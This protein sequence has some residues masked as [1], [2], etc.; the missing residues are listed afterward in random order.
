L[1]LLL[2]VCGVAAVGGLLLAIAA[3]VGQAA[4]TAGASQ[5]LHAALADAEARGSVHL[6]TSDV[7]N[8]EE[9]TFADDVAT[10]AG[11]R[12]IAVSDGSRAQIVVTGQ[13]VYISGNRQALAGYFGFSAT[14]AAR[15]G[16][17]WFSTPV[18]KIGP[19]ALATAAVLPSAL[20]EITPAA[21]LTEMTPSTLG[22]EA[23]I[24]IQGS[25]PAALKLPGVETLYVSR[26]PRPLPVFATIVLTNPGNAGETINTT[27]GDWGERVAI[28]TPMHA[29]PLSRL[30]PAK[31]APA[32]PPPTSG[33]TAPKPGG[34]DFEQTIL[35]STFP[36]G[37]WTPL[38]GVSGGAVITRTCS[39]HCAYAISGW[40]PPPGGL[41][42]LQPSGHSWQGTST[43]TAICASRNQQPSSVSEHWTLD[44]TNNGRT[45]WAQ[46]TVIDSA[47]CLPGH[48]TAVIQ[49]TWQ[50]A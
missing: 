9:T 46:I 22:G 48:G 14:V 26:S 42:Q 43:G 4:G 28:A 2:A 30:Q 41:L 3:P 21:N 1:R 15:I 38:D 13:L 25:A 11:R 35:Q 31:V 23:V 36:S 27:L 7:L 44:F 45:M 50:D 24:G 5:L 47:G 12:D 16:T 10:R 8:S 20:A 29:I 6:A 39:G 34:W 33:F 40:N 18:S 17:G 37:V 19:A 32:P 49:G